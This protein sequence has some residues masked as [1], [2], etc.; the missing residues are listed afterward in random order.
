M[1]SKEVAASYFA[2]LANGES[3]FFKPKNKWS[4]PGNNKFSDLKNNLDKVCKMFEH[5]MIDTSVNITVKPD[6][7]MMKSVGLVAVPVWSAAIGLCAVLCGFF[8]AL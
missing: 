5:V 8:A 4:Q 3:P 6:G 1:E 7:T 2:A